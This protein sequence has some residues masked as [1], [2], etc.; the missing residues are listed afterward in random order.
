MDMF[1][2]KDWIQPYT[3]GCFKSVWLVDPIDCNLVT[4]P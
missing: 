1:A 4:Q 3:I 2:N